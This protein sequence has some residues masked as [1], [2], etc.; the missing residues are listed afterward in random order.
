MKTMDVTIEEEYSQLLLTDNTNIYL[1]H[2]HYIKGV[3]SKYNTF[4]TYT[5]YSDFEPH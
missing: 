4:C 5:G 2:I 1:V 3:V